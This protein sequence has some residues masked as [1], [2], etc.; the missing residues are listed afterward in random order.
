[1]ICVNKKTEDLENVTEVLPL[2]TDRRQFSFDS[3]GTRQSINLFEVDVLLSVTD[4]EEPMD[5]GGDIE[6]E[7]I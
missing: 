1:M 5:L 3:D 7:V 4:Y 2:S 6:T